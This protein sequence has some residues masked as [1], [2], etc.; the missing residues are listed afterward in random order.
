MLGGD[1]SERFFRHRSR[2]GKSAVHT[3][4]PLGWNTCLVVAGLH[5]STSPLLGICHGLSLRHGCG[6]RDDVCFAYVAGDE[7]DSLDAGKYCA[8][9]FYFVDGRHDIHGGLA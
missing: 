4:S 2:H 6:S 7:T 9:Y 1:D 5:E 8:A 3:A